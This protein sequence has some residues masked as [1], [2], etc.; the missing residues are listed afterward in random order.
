VSFKLG[1]P[2]AKTIRPDGIVHAIRGRKEWSALVEVKVGDNPLDG[3]QVDAYHRL[4]RQECFDALITISN[5]AALPNGLPPVPLDG[6]RLRKIPVVHLSWERLLAEARMLSNQKEVEDP[7]QHW[8]L[9]E[10]IKYV[11]DEESRIIEPPVLGK[12][13]GGVLQAA[14]E[15][16][17]TAVSTQLTDVIEH[18]D[19][20]LRKLALRLRAKMGV[21]VQRRTSRA[22]VNDPAGRIKRIHADALDGGVLTGALRVPDAIGDLRLELMLQ[23]K[24]V[25]YSVR[26]RAPG[27]GRTKTR[28]N[29]LLRELRGEALPS[30][31]KL[32]VDWD[33][34]RL[35]SEASVDALQEDHKPLMVDPAGEPILGEALPRT[36][37]LSWATGLAKGRGRAGG[38][39]LTGISAGVERFYRQVIEGLVPYIP[40]APRLP[41]GEPDESIP[42][43]SSPRT[44]PP[45]AHQP[46]ETPVTTQFN[47]QERAPGAGDGTEGPVRNETRTAAPEGSSADWDSLAG[48]AGS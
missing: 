7:D 9:D 33:R 14:K 1:E 30:G 11:A 47:E 21:E 18:W 22:D 15:H 29:W 20:F 25:R 26:F 17:L 39:V 38:H 4:A 13:W 16:R 43:R 31:L 8:M 48:K 19:A 27:E 37:T 24:V 3:D 12:Y 10:W 42:E 46:T 32:R 23:G 36:F 28:L 41:A 44:P 6:R 5:Q 45:P 2:P 34:R 40:K 35:Y